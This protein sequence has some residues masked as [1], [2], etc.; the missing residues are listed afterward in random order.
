MYQTP[1]HLIII[2]KRMFIFD[3]TRNPASWMQGY[4]LCSGDLCCD[5]YEIAW[6][7]NSW[8]H[9][10]VASCP[11]LCSRFSRSD[12]CLVRSLVRT[13]S[14]WASASAFA[15]GFFL[16]KYLQYHILPRKFVQT[17]CPHAR[18]RENIKNTKMTDS[19][20]RSIRMCETVSSTTSAGTVLLFLTFSDRVSAIGKRSSTTDA[21]HAVRLLMNS[22]GE[23]GIVAQ[24]AD[25]VGMLLTKSS[26]SWSCRSI[27][28]LNP[29]SAL[30]RHK[31]HC[32]D[33][34]YHL[35]YGYSRFSM[36]HPLCAPTLACGNRTD[37]TR[38]I[39]TQ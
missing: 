9:L 18:A 26:V 34:I 17:F 23:S 20:I 7:T 2:W 13:S 6:C 21:I 32:W 25:G 16:L 35:W 3:T 12:V 22:H 15:M 36:R 1:I 39:I 11:L 4:V 10:S 14:H 29:T 19:L 8:V 38:Y 27:C 37:G 30:Q 24:H 5:L 31:P 33:Q 28:W